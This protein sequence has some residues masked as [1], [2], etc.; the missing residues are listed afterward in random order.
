MAGNNGRLR[1]LWCLNGSN[2]PLFHFV[3]VKNGYEWL[4]MVYY[5]NASLSLL[6]MVMVD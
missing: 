6:W 1:E 2:S 5:N 3:M 4:T